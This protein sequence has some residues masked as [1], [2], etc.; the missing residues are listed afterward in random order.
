MAMKYET[1]HPNI[2]F[3][4]HDFANAHGPS[5]FLPPGPYGM[6]QSIVHA[7]R[8][9]ATYVACEQ[10]HDLFAMCVRYNRHFS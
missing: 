3:I 7:L 10:L 8:N 1:N 5:R 2:E 6:L 9:R 4:S